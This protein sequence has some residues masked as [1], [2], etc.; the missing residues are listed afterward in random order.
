M[1][2]SGTIISFQLKLRFPLWEQLPQRVFCPRCGKPMAVR[3]CSGS[4]RFYYLRSRLRHARESEHCAY[5][6]FVPHTWDEAAWDCVYAILKDES[7]VGEKLS[8]AE[9]QN[10][11]IDKLVRLEQQKITRYQNKIVKVREGYEGGLYNLDEAKVKVNGYQELIGKVEQ[12]VKRLT[13]LMSG[14]ELTV[15]VEELKKKLQRLAHENLEKATFTEKR[16]IINKLGIRVYPSED[17]KTMKIRC[18]LN[19]SATEPPRSDQCRIIEFALLGS[20]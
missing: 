6:R 17:L 1:T 14:Q 12:E 8:Q 16:D 2:G 4:D 20:Q 3:H 5:H 9:K 15:N 18:S 7:W 10:Q 11:D 19:F 13:S